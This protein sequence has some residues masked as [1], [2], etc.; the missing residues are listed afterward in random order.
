MTREQVALFAVA[1]PVARIVLAAGKALRNWPAGRIAAGAS[2][3][4][5]ALFFALDLAGARPGGIAGDATFVIFGLPLVVLFVLTYA[6]GR[7]AT[8]AAKFV[9]G[10]R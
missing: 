2:V 8:E 5:L 9:W 6:V 3:A 1:F 10:K 7:G 4:V